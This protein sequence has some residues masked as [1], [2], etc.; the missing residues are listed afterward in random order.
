M[1]PAL[2]VVLAVVIATYATLNSLFTVNLQKKIHFE[3]VIAVLAASAVGLL[4][5]V[6]V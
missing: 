3:V 4:V 6:V 2:I 5:V 1:L